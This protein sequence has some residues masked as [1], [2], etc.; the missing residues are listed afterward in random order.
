M[1]ALAHVPTV[2][3]VGQESC[4]FAVCAPH[5]LALCPCH[6]SSRVCLLAIQVLPQ[7]I[8]EFDYV[9]PARFAG[10]VSS[11]WTVIA[12]FLKMAE[13]RRKTKELPESCGKVA[14]LAL[15][16]V[17]PGDLGELGRCAKVAEELPKFV[18]HLFRD[19]A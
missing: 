13:K 2:G 3:R 14:C 5:L 10:P 12:A 18:E 11:A 15:P 9:R 1:R 16:N 4:A 19:S 8:V 7:F 6:L 17:T